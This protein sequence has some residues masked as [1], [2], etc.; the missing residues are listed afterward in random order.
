M[1]SI[2]QE[3]FFFV[4]SRKKRIIFLLC[5]PSCQ[6]KSG[7]DR[8][9]RSFIPSFHPF[10]IYFVLFSMSGGPKQAGGAVPSQPSQLAEEVDGIV[11][12]VE[13]AELSLQAKQERPILFKA[14]V[15]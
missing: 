11:V 4:F 9:F 12:E 3:R 6:N 13:E 2:L 8:C 14:F 5:S 1:F 10:C 15:C 7:L